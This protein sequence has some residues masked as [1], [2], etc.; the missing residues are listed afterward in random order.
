M[1]D[2][3]SKLTIN[4]DEYELKD[5][6]ARADIANA[7]DDIAQAQ[8]DIA[9]AQTDITEKILYFTNQPVSVATNAQIM[10]VP[11]SGTNSAITTNTVVLD[12]VFGAPAVIVSDVSWT[13][14]NGYI[15][16]SGTCTMATTANVTLG[17]KGN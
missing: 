11:A 7:Q 10:R 14:Y 17:Q 13:S 4:G 8:D 9:E 2:L 12:C 6:V 16:F 1:A 3:A 15:T 5:A